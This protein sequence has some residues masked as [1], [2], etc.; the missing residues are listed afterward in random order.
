MEAPRNPFSDPVHRQTEWLRARKLK[1]RL[2][3]ETV[4]YCCFHAAI[5]VG[6]IAVGVHESHGPIWIFLALGGG[7]GHSLSAIEHAWE[8][9]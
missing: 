1:R 8:D 4:A 3:L 9:R 2:T 6:L 7:V 5:I